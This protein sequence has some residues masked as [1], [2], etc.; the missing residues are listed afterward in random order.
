MKKVKDTRELADIL[1]EFDNWR[2][3]HDENDENADVIFE[4]NDGSLYCGTLFTYQNL[5][6]LAKR[7]RVSGECLFGKY[8]YCDKPVFIEKMD[9]PTIISV[10][11]DIIERGEVDL[12]F[13]RI[14]RKKQ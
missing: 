3:G 2:G 8:F 4:L 9:K 1:F 12:A 6:T 7:N 10:I 5:L 14:D 13:A 11:N